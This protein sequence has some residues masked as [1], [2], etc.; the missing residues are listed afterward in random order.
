[1]CKDVRIIICK[2]KTSTGGDS[3]WNMVVWIV[4]CCLFDDT[5][6][7][8]YDVKFLLVN[9][10]IQL[11]FLCT[12]YKNITLLTDNVFNSVYKNSKKKKCYPYNTKSVNSR[13]NGCVTKTIPLFSITRSRYNFFIGR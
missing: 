13:K 1:M 12:L 7:F 6:A 11:R 4:C 8:L 9:K 10:T 2:D 3:L 5:S